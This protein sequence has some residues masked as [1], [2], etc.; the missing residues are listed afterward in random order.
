MMN[1]EDWGLVGVF[2]AGAIPWMEAIAVIPAGIIIGLN[3]VAT[4]VA[5]VVGNLITI[6]LF[7]Y[8]GSAIRE[9]FIKRRVKRGKSAN[10]PKLEKALKAFD[11]YGVYGLAALGPILIGTQFAA[12]ASVAAGVKPLK[13]SI[14]VSASM[15]IWASLIAVAIAAFD[16]NFEVL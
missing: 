16:L 6:V 10:I 2:I 14:L 13:A 9:R 5:A 11:N 12:A 4:L 3:P 7:A 8:F 15:V 1:I